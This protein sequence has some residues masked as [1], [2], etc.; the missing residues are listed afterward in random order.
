MIR[1]LAG[2]ALLVAAAPLLQSC[3]PLAVTGM[4]AAAFMATDR[5]TSGTYIEDESIE[6]KAVARL[7]EDSRGAHVNATSYNRKVLLTGEVRDEAMKAAVE[8]EVRNVGGVSAIVN[9]LAIGAASKYTSRS[10]LHPSPCP[11]PSPWTHTAITP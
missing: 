2:I 10:I 5:R 7:R 1:K 6:W 8:R 9:E 3:F 4:G 11:P